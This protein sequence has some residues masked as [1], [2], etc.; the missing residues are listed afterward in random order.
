MTSATTGRVGDF[1]PAN[2]AAQALDG[3]AFDDLILGG[4]GVDMIS[5][6]AGSDTID[7]GLLS[8]MIF[9]GADN[10]II[11]YT[12]GQGSD[13]VD[14]GA[15]TD[16][17]NI[18]GVLGNDQLDVVLTGTVISS[19]ELGGISNVEQFT[20]NL[21]GGTNTLSYGARRRVP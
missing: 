10:D 11:N 1:I 17:L 5:G 7:G 15:G 2:G 12:M 16:K 4:G 14:G 9:A 20:A 21:G 18:L 19:V 6:L 13:T 8:D 3:T